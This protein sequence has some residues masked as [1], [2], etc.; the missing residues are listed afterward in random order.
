M[1]I[2]FG[3]VSKKP[4]VGSKEVTEAYVGAQKVY[5]AAP[6]IYYGFL[7]T[8]N[9]Y[10][11]A[12]WCQLGN[13]TSIVKNDNI[14]RISLSITSTN[15]GRITINEIKGNKFKFTVKGNNLA[16]LQIT[17]VVNGKET[18]STISEI[19]TTDYTLKSYDVPTGTT[20]I[21]LNCASAYNL[22]AGYFD[23]IRFENE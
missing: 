13:A 15:Y 8:E 3:S 6:P 12:S 17:F 23:A 10:V 11:L 22:I 1:G 4:Y 19:T 7:G 5:S 21:I 14:Y 2:S 20:Q 18:T 16:T 9:D